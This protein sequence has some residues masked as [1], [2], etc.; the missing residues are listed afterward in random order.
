MASGGP[1]ATSLPSR[2]AALGPQVHDPVAVADDVEVVLD[3]DDGVAAR[4]QVVQHLEQALHVG[5]VQAHGRLVEQVERRAPPRAPRQ[6]ARDLEA[7]RLAARELGGRLAELEV[8][9][10]DAAQ[11]VQRRG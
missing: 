8:A 4:G 11:D 1:S 10:P 2:L 5:E 7:L 9:E 3:R 6:L